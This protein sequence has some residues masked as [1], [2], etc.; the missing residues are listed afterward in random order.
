MNQKLTTIFSKTGDMKYIS[1]L[2]LIR[3]FQRASRRASL[4]VSITKG[5]SPHL[6]ISITKA[7]R[8]GVE[9]ESEEAI[10]YMDEKL[11]PDHFVKFINEYLPAGIKVLS[12]RGAN[13]D[14]ERNI[15][16]CNAA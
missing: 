7:L 3:M 1:H 10:F 5:F 14:A 2:D 6:K 15:H 13:I 11:E 16:K 12:A 9:S 8:L 4:P